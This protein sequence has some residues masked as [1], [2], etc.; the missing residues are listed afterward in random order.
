MNTRCIG[1]PMLLGVRFI[2]V[3][4]VRAWAR[5]PEDWW[6]CELATGVVDWPKL[7][8]QMQVIAGWDPGKSAM[9]Q[10]VHID[11]LVALWGRVKEWHRQDTDCPLGELS[12]RW[13]LLA[14]QTSQELSDAFQHISEGTEDTWIDS[15]MKSAWE[16]LMSLSATWQEIVESRWPIF[17]AVAMTAGKLSG[18][19]SHEQRTG[20]AQVVNS[21]PGDCKHEEETR[22]RFEELLDEDLIASPKLLESALATEWVRPCPVAVATVYVLAAEFHLRAREDGLLLQPSEAERG[23]LRRAE[24]KIRAH[25]DMRLLLSSWPLWRALDRF[26]CSGVINATVV[27]ASPPAK[28][29]LWLFVSRARA[30]DQDLVV[31]NRI[32]AD[33]AVH[34]PRE[35]TTLMERVAQSQHPSRNKLKVV[36][37]GAHYGDCSLWASAVFS[38]KV[39]C[40][41]VEA[42]PS[43]WERFQRAKVA[44]RFEDDTLLALHGFVADPLQSSVVHDPSLQESQYFRFIPRLTVDGIIREPVDVLKVHT[45]GGEHLVLLG[46][47]A[48]FARGV[49]AVVVAIFNSTLG[50]RS[51]LFLAK[52]GYEVRIGSQRL[53][54]G[55]LRRASYIGKILEAEGRKQ[56]VGTHP[57]L[58][59]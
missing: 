44:N 22:R 31:S 17:S 6:P 47:R 14:S 36:E 8:K 40:V 11:L 3:A 27:S 55:K 35:F 52:R 39:S 54:P 38:P 49:R 45:N 48:T 2:L 57:R 53:Q 1:I 24:G 43:R 30:A 20:G 4:V 29:W 18:R 33:R 25:R 26:T 50:L 37:V 32:R 15:L 9:M 12:F 7:K 59:S 21:E 51:A 46:A 42:D 56:M 58:V 13:Q 41:G 16:D 19:R 23:L 10:Q 5:P 28:G 34:C